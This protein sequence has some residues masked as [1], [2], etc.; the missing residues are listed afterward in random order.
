MRMRGGDVSYR[1]EIGLGEVARGAKVP[2]TLADGSSV[3]VTI[4]SGVEV[5]AGAPPEGQG[6]APASAAAHRATR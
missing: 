4:P 2:I 6:L 5:G 1:L 3:E